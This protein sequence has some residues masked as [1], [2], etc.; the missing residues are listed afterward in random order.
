M[1]SES[2]AR[3][4]H[5]DQHPEM[6]SRAPTEARHVPATATPA[7]A[8][9]RGPASSVA[10]L[11][12]AHLQRAAGNAAVAK[13]LARE[14]Q[15][16]APAKESAALP[17]IQ[18][19]PQGPSEAKVNE[20]LPD[21]Y[22]AM[23]EGEKVNAIRG[24]LG[25][26]SA[27]VISRAWSRLSAPLETARA[28]PDL[29]AASV[30]RSAA[31]ADLPPFAAL[32][33]EF[34]AAVL[35]RARGYLDSNKE[36]VQAERART[37]VPTTGENAG[38]TATADQEV[39]K[40]QQLAPE[41]ERA[42]KAKAELLRIQLGTEKRGK[43]DTQDLY[44]I[45]FQPGSPPDARDARTMYDAVLE[46]WNAGVAVESALIK[47]CP[48]AAFFMGEGGDPS[49]ISATTDIKV[50]RAEITK[51]LDDLE[52]RILAAIPRIGN[53]VNFTDLVPIH[54]EL[55]VGPVWSK[56]VESAVA[57]DAISGANVGEV[58][59][60][61]GL[62]TLSAAAFLFG[63][64]A[65]GGLATFLFAAGAGV[66]GAQAGI[67]WDKYFDLAAA[68]KGSID[69]AAQLVS[70]EQ[71]DAAM[72]SAALD[73]IF[74]AIDLWQ[75][76]SGVKKAAEAAS[77]TRKGGEAFVAG[78]KAGA[79]SGAAVLLKNLQAADKPGEVLARA[80]AEIGPEG[81]QQLSG[82]P[83]KRL[84]EIA[85][86]EATPLGQRFL[87]LDAKGAG[88]VSE[89]TKEL[90]AKL[91]TLI[92]EPDAGKADEILA[93][94][95]SQYGYKGVLEKVGGWGVIKGSAVMKGGKGSAAGL[96]GWRAGLV[97][98]LDRFIQEA[99]DKLAKTVRT[100]S[101]KASSDLDVQIMG[102]TAA[103]L[104]KQA[105]G[106]LANRL[107]TDFTGAKKLLDVTVFIDPTRAHLVDLLRDLGE[108]VRAQIRSE[109]ATIEPP[110][111]MGSRLQAARKYGEEA[112][113][114]HGEEVG[115]KYAKEAVDRVMED[116]RRAGV[117]PD[118]A[119]VRLTPAEQK[120]FATQIDGWMTELKNPE[121]VEFRAD[122]VRKVSR[123]QA[124]IDAS[125]A[126]SYVGG[127]VAVW[128][129]GRD[130]DASKIADALKSLNIDPTDV[131]KFSLAQR[132]S[133]A[134]AEGK[135]LD[136]AVNNLRE[137]TADDLNMLVA[138]VKDI[139]KHGARAA[140]VLQ[141]P[142]KT[143]VGQLTSLMNELLN[144]G[145][146]TPAELAKVADAGGLASMRTEISGLLDS[147]SSATGGAITTLQKQAGDLGVSLTGEMADFKSLLK[148]HMRFTALTAGAKNATAAQIRVLETTLQEA[149]KALPQESS[150]TP[151]F[152]LPPPQS[153]PPTAP[154][155]TAP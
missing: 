14:A 146:L 2:G 135:W 133:A 12:I 9:L 152:L 72:I 42:K 29:F 86:G 23:N 57:R 155:P 64:F 38:E 98:E 102:E 19:E 134:L 100:G 95:I 63:S 34:E 43:G 104:Q 78:G 101:E 67:S 1:V 141:V 51:G 130:I 140:E 44:P 124:L 33:E 116:A 85:G 25:S 47:K 79:A 74:A 37:G 73:T 45:I 90:I 36:A 110:L 31:V 18:R 96:E 114:K 15:A 35:G 5:A 75:G 76:A 62:S 28:N 17:T 82:L 106:W 105:E 87:L 3:L 103:D 49:K 143:N 122:Y 127:G 26:A 32:K 70:G 24:L 132:I 118:E 109:M 151:E 77:V 88:A 142:G 120:H 126:D 41:M 91:P 119:F 154:A 147:L 27:S 65:S 50:A 4:E 84:A 81:A 136:A 8:G 108:D 21:G 148:W 59:K 52:K 94:G 55:L 48:S 153:V 138:A 7:L 68:H 111:I 137:A 53:G 61:L 11:P 58:L 56:P 144:Y 69:P 54:Q 117:K 66:S 83:Y 80:V 60:T 92:S 71:V 16:H 93:A 123:A 13:L 145:R 46:K 139:A 121:K 99:S 129:T 112:I 113:A 89:E 20:G 125:H 39:Q 115:G 128:V 10:G 30:K 97:E 6:P 107:G 22:E 131:G 149:Q 150:E 40:I